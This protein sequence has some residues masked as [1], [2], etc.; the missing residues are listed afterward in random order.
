MLGQAGGSTLTDVIVQTVERTTGV[1]KNRSD[2]VSIR[3]G[4]GKG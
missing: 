4:E 3:R 2:S 1:E